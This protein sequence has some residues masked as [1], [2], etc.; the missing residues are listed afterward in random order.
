MSDKTIEDYRREWE[1]R[2]VEEQALL[3]SLEI[4]TYENR[5]LQAQW[6]KKREH[7]EGSDHYAI[8]GTTG[9]T[10]GCPKEVFD[11]LPEGKAYVLETVNTS[12]ITGWIIDGK[13]YDRK[14]DQDLKREHEA[15]VADLDRR[16]REMLDANREDWQRRQDALPDW[17]RR[18]LETFHSR[19]GEKFARDGWG[20]E[21]IIAEL[22]VEYAALGDVILDKDVFQVS[23]HESEAIKTISREQGTSG[24]QHSMALALAKAHLEDPDR[25]MVGTVSALSPLTGDAFYDGGRSG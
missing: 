10:A 23:D 18:R 15:F 6:V 14:S 19:A 20:Y 22:A 24:N 13:W 3:E 25:S 4:P 17:I 8:T 1:R 12:R 11:L 21:L 2:D 9:W 7:A 5:R 16:H